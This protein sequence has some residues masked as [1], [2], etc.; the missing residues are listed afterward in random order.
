MM[1]PVGLPRPDAKTY[2][3][4]ASSIEH[5]LDRVAA[6]NPN[7]SAPG[8]HRLNRA[9]YANAVRDLTLVHVDPAALLPVDDAVFGFDNNAGALTSSPALIEAYVSAA[10]KISRAALGHGTDI[11]Q[12]VYAAPSDYSQVYPEEGMMFGSRGGMKVTHFFPADGEYAFDFTLVRANAGGLVGQAAGEF[13][14]MSLDGKRLRLYDIQKDTPQGGGTAADRHPTRATVTAGEHTIEAVFIA[15]TA[16]PADDFNKHFERTSLTQG[17][18]GF[19]FFTHVN[20]VSVSGPFDGKRA[21]SS[22]SRDHILVCKPATAAEELPCA[23]KILATLASR[24]FRRPS[25][26][27]DVERLLNLYQAGRNEGDFEDGNRTRD[28]QMILSD[29]EFVYRTGA[30]TTARSQARA[31]LSS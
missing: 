16:I 11:Q 14:D 7:L 23:K 19:N 4:L 27:T 17:V 21:Q 25:N 1:P 20:S 24:A 31:G 13:L 5:E 26:G 3:M 6:A 8:A 22:L 10:A 18:P 9:E 12:K 28:W 15:K 29:P 30:K 2:E